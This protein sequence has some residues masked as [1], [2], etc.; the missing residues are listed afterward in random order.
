MIMSRVPPEVYISISGNGGIFHN[1]TPHTYTHGSLYISSG[2]G[3][4]ALRF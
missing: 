1:H 2:L 4:R 3:F